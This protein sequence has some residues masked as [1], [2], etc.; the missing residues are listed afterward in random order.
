[1]T[2]T[3]TTEG[4]IRRAFWQGNAQLRS[5]FKRGKAQNDYNATI[6]SEWVEFVD[7]LARDGHISEALT[8]HRLRDVKKRF[9]LCV[10]DAAANTAIAR[11]RGTL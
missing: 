8:E 1:M 7:M 9:S 6:R 5:Q 11:A 3:Y 2:H 4:A 10:A